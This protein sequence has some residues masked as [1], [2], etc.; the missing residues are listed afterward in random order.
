M[1]ETKTKTGTEYI[2]LA[3]IVTD[4][5]DDTIYAPVGTVTANNDKLAIRA[6]VGPE[7]SARNYVAVPVRSFKVRPV[8]ASTETKITVG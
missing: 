3:V 7:P 4:D 8:G 5:S 2:V 1:T 6:A